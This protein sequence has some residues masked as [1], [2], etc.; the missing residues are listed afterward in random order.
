MYLESKT[1]RIFGIACLGKKLA[2]DTEICY[3]FEYFFSKIGLFDRVKELFKSNQTRYG[4]SPVYLESKTERIF[5]IAY[6]GKKLA[7]DTEIC[8]YFEYF[9]SKIGLFDRVKELFKSNQTRYGVSPG[10]VECKTEKIFGIACLGK[11][12]V[13]DTEIC[14]YFEYFFSKIEK[15]YWVKELFKVN[16]IDIPDYQYYLGCNTKRMVRLT[17]LEKKFVSQSE[18]STFSLIL[19][20]KI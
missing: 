17:F 12:L 4:V 2:F 20:S 15:F 8:Y 14:Y 9:F 11:K 6:V 1:E 13:F 16:Q 3:Y 18:I 19:F 7:F 10:Y 5:G